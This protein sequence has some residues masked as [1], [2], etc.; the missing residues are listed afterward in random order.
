MPHQ[1]PWPEEKNEG[2][3][4]QQHKTTNEGKFGRVPAKA[5]NCLRARFLLSH[6]PRGS[7]RGNVLPCTSLSACRLASTHSL[8]AEM[9]KGSEKWRV[10]AGAKRSRARARTPGPYE[11]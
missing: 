7:L 1:A 4:K 9:Q 2:K 8:S 11:L 6:W 3:R 10:R 5:R